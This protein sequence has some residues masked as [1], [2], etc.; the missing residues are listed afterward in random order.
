MVFW[1][2]SV[3]EIKQKKNDEESIEEDENLI[4]NKICIN[5]PNSKTRFK[6]CNFLQG[7]NLLIPGH[8]MKVIKRDSNDNLPFFLSEQSDQTY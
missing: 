3:L 8:L 7:E 6:L 4:V 5:M 2:G 1:N